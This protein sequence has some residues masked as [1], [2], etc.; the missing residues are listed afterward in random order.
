MK[1]FSK[2][3]YDKIR[4]SSINLR[5]RNSAESFYCLFVWTILRAEATPE[6]DSKSN[7]IQSRLFQTSDI[8]YYHNIHIDGFLHECNLYFFLFFCFDC[9]TLHP[10]QNTACPAYQSKFVIKGGLVLATPS[11][12]SQKHMFEG[13]RN[14]ST[15]NVMIASGRGGPLGLALRGI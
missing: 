7:P 3:L 8:L 6:P 9:N 4:R 13:G 15:R 14:M 12:R 1:N 5:M 2:T 10:S 11:L